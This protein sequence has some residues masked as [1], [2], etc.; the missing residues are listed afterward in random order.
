MAIVYGMSSL[1]LLFINKKSKEDDSNPSYR[2][3]WVQRSWQPFFVNVHVVRTSILH[4][5]LLSDH[6]HPL[7]PKFEHNDDTIHMK[8]L[9]SVVHQ[10]W[11]EPTC[12]C[13]ADHKWR[14]ESRP[15]TAIQ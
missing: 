5:I 13:V 15:S 6:H 2:S 8:G 1:N 3:C 14:S 9:C 4:P 10:F 12:L 7:F 11:S